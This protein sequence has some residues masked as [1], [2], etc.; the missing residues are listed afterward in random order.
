MF[1][2]TPSMRPFSQQRA[3]PLKFGSST[4]APSPF[5]RN[6]A[7]S[8][9]SSVPS[10]FSSSR[11]LTIF[12]SLKNSA[13]PETEDKDE[14]EDFPLDLVYDVELHITY[15]R[16]EKLFETLKIIDNEKAQEDLMTNYQVSPGSSTMEWLQDY[17][18]SHHTYE[19]LPLI[20]EVGPGGHS[21]H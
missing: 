13:K 18:P 8:I 5:F 21:L 11:G 16:L 9:P 6:R 4:K 20:K 19:E 1:R 12:K 10:S 2:V 14:K 17:P 3:I 7:S 15:M